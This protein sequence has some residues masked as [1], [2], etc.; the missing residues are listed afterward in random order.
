[1]TSRSR[2]PCAIG[3]DFGTESGR[4]VVVDIHTGQELASSVYAYAHGVINEVLPSNG[5]RLPPQWA[6][7]DP[8]DYLRTLTLTI[9]EALR[10]ANVDGRDVI[11]LGVDFTS[12]T[13]LPVDAGGQPLCFDERF[14]DDPHAWVKLWKHHDAQPDAD[15]VNQVGRERGEAFLARYGGKVSSESFVPKVLQVLRES[16]RVYERASR[17]IEAG[18]WVVLQLTG[19]E[20]RNAC[21]AGYKALWAK[22]SG[23]PSPEYF[24]ALD[25]RLRHLVRDKL[26][27]DIY[28]Q[29]A[30]AG[31]LTE[32]AATQL[33]LQP[34]IAVA[35]ANV[36]AHVSV[37]ACGVTGPG[38]VV[39]VMGTSICHLALT[40]EQHLV[41]GISGVVE[42]GIIPG[43]YGYE[44]GQSAAGDILG[45]F[46][47]TCVPPGCGDEASRRGLDIYALL[48][49]RAS[50][51]RPGE[52]GLLALDWWN[53]NR[54]ILNDADL[55]GL[56]LGATLHT[57]PEEMY[58]ALIE[59]S[60]FGTNAILHTFRDH[61]VP[62]DAVVACGGLP[63][64]NALLMQIFA[65]VTGR[66]IQVSA[67][68]QTAALGAAMFGAVAAGSA[69]GGYDDIVAAARAMA[70]LKERAFRPNADAQAMYARL[71][72]EYV[73]L[74][75]HFGRGE[76]PVMKTLAALRR[77]AAAARHLEP[78][79]T[80]H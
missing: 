25:P 29:G 53:G 10:L 3:L 47:E 76:N 45:W 27:T 2:H 22:R 21:A 80:M 49:E 26:A 14:R 69:A 34:A 57:R 51:L 9:P 37:P 48:E 43:Y 56:V 41:P 75:D 58:R 72:A 40:G 74:H 28:P 67:S 16:P 46:V 64:R 42:D 79:P 6:L 13:M 5:A 61:G 33:G 19:Q 73:R 59:A 32:A 35:V 12:C 63:E 17:F 23:Y 44:A 65:D 11:G 55:S 1:M 71:Y 7:Q 54:S 38:T 66:A 30:R 68:S 8:A 77:E 31:R 15:R 70:H 36:D 60:A 39:M 52:S 20:R 62:V 50:A 4:A 78:S 18:D 24:A